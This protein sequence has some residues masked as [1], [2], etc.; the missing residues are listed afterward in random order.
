MPGM[1]IISNCS[2]EATYWISTLH[3]LNDKSQQ[4]CRNYIEDEINHYTVGH[5]GSESGQKDQFRVAIHHSLC[6]NGII[7]G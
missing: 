4:V 6:M 3:T 7:S 5:V 1:I 2:E